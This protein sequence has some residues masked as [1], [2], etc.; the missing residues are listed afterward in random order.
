[1][2]RTFGAQMLADS[3]TPASRPGLPWCRVFDAGAVAIFS[4]FHHKSRSFQE[5]FLALLKLHQ[6]DYDPRYLWD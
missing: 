2:C 1:M 5:E 3:L 6:I 4:D